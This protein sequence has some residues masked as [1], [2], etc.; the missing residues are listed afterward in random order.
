MKIKTVSALPNGNMKLNLGL[1]DEKEI[2][3]RDDEVWLKIKEWKKIKGN[4]ITPY[5]R[6]LEE[7]KEKAK[8]RVV[9]MLDT[10][11]KPLTSTYCL[12]EVSSWS[13]KAIQARAFADT[14]EVGTLLA[15]EAEASGDSVDDL[16]M[17]IITKADHY[18]TRVARVSAFR[19]ETF[20]SIE[21][22]KT[23]AEIQD[24]ISVA[25]VAT[26]TEAESLGLAS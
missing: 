16:A 4:E 13:Q 5:V 6:D 1:K 22:A 2:D 10:L 14:G 9:R 11:T 7:E 26:T 21:K 8:V 15:A 23:L 24:V 3:P 17:L 12:E 19:R 20:S 25:L 18:E